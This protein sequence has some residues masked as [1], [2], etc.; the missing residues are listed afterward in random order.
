MRNLRRARPIIGAAADARVCACVPACT[1]KG[2]EKA[3]Y[4]ANGYCARI[5][6]ALAEMAY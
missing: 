5:A 6:V 2:P 1:A 3:E 4:N